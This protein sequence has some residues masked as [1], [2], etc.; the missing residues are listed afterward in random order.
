[1]VEKE[2]MQQESIHKIGD[3]KADKRNL[4]VWDACPICGREHWQRHSRLGRKCRPCSMKDAQARPEVRAKRSASLK[5]RKCPWNKAT[6]FRRRGKKIN[7]NNSPEACEHRSQSKV[8]QWS[9]PIIRETITKSIKESHNTPKYLEENSI[10]KKNDWNNPIQ[11]SKMTEGIRNSRTPEFKRK[12]SERQK[13]LW[14]DPQ[15]RVVWIEALRKSKNT[16]ESRERSRQNALEQW[17]DPIKRGRIISSLLKMRSPNKHEVVIQDILDNNYPN[18]WKFVG[19]GMVI[20]A[21]LNHDFININGK[22]WIIE[23]FGNYWHHKGDEEFRTKAFAEFGY[24]TLVI[25]GGK[26]SV[27]KQSVTQIIKE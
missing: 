10:R 24:R 3:T 19:D 26:S 9:N 2:P 25:W 12:I 22:K 27:D 8:M 16:Q 4:L 11:R 14:A 13:Q 7:V 1:M 20:I 5:G 23:Y 15:K 6:A 18:E 17:Q 21:G